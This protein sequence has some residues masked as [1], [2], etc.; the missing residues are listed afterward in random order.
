MHLA[1]ESGAR[2]CSR[3]LS[4]R[5]TFR[6]VVRRDAWLAN[7]AIWQPRT[8]E[9]GWQAPPRTAKMKEKPVEMPT[10][11]TPASAQSTGRSKVPSIAPLAIAAALAMVLHLVSGIMLNRSHASP[12]IEP[13]AS[14]AAGE[15]LTCTTET[16][17]QESSLPYD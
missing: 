12:G 5:F 6:A 11:T 1:A 2:G 3:A 4:K 8:F 10:K 17:P 15:E 16:R 9:V 14:A 7:I 13:A